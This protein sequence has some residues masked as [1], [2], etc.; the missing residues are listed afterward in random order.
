MDLDKLKLLLEGKDLGTLLPA[1]EELLAKLEP[2]LKILVLAGPVVMIIMG[3]L[4][5]VA[6]PREANYHFGYRCYFGMGS[7]EAWRFTQR[8][9]GIIWMLLGT[10]LLAAAL[11][12]NGRMAGL[13]LMD[14]LLQSMTCVLWQ[15]GALLVSNLLIRIIV[16]CRFD[17]K[18][19]LRSE[20]RK[21]M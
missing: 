18:G 10:G 4:Y 3:F 12:A 14:G 16:A 9:A 19:N 21:V 11:M 7:V 5:L 17:R 20:K 15:M 13:A 8:L 2:A 6:A 1:P